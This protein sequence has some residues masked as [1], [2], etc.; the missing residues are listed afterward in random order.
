MVISHDASFSDKDLI[1]HWT[2]TN[3]LHCLHQVWP[4]RTLI[5]HKLWLQ[6]TKNW[7][8]NISCWCLSKIQLLFPDRIWLTVIGDY[9]T[10]WSSDLWQKSWPQ[11]L[12]WCRLSVSENLTLQ[13]EQLS[14]CSSFTQWSAAERPGCSLTDQ[15]K[16]RPRP[17][18]TR[19]LLWSLD[20]RGRGHTDSTVKNSYSRI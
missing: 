17:S 1:Q 4:L 5:H 9:R 20:Q 19:I 13:L 14:T 11:F 2:L 16:T 3:I 7:S 15:L 18:P 12:Q 6:C 10:V 8:E